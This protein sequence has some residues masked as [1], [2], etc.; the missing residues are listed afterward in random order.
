MK[1]DP[2]HEEL[3][4]KAKRALNLADADTAKF[5]QTTAIGDHPGFLRMLAKV[6]ELMGEDKLI[7]G[8]AGGSNR[9]IS[10]AELMYPSKKQ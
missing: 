6:G 3:L 8:A 5:L 10:L 1:A 2:K 9:E 7:E 4:G